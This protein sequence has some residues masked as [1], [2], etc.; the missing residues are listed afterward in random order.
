M[1]TTTATGQVASAER[2]VGLANSERAWAIVCALVRHGVR[3]VFVCPGSRS[4]PLVAAAAAHPELE[5]FLFYDERTAGFAA[6]GAGRVGAPAAVLTT[7]GTAV[8]NLHPALVEADL[9]DVPL[10]ALTADRPWELVGTGANQTIDQAGLFGRS[11]RS[12]ID[13]AAPPDGA[14]ADRV[15]RQLDAALASLGGPRPGPVHLNARFRKPLEPSPEAFREPPPP[16]APRHRASRLALGSEERVELQATLSRAERGLVVVGSL[17]P[18]QRAAALA[19][20]ERLGWPAVPD[21][22]SGLPRPLPVPTWLPAVA[23]LPEVAAALRPDV[24]LW[25]GGRTTEPRVATWV[26]EANA[27]VFQVLPTTAARDPDGTAHVLLHADLRELLPLVEGAPPSGLAALDARVQASRAD[28]PPVALSEP[29]VARAVT[30][31]I[32]PGELLLVG[33]SMPVRDV[34]RFADVLAAGASVL[35]NRGASGIDGNVGTALGACLAHGR[36]PTTALLG[37]LTFL[38]DAAALQAAVQARAPLRV[39]VVNNRGGGIFSFLPVAGH[40][41]VFEP[42]FG[43]PHDVDVVALARAWGAAA[44]RV[45]DVAD[46]RTRLGTPPE[47]PE[48][49]EVRTDRADNL[50]LHRALDEQAARRF[51]E[52]P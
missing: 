21:V 49:L 50:E 35:C 16:G 7:S 26:Q 39:V 24:V 25:L 23:R 14:S 47:R 18:G 8:A 31:S 12:F 29:A 46:L 42:F 43:T 37:D 9:D 51:R 5:L 33:N 1:T 17:P 6:V 36:A 2:A 40:A 48:V 28:L 19:V 3:R 32:R 52:A 15:T 11:A 44:S 27:R 20:V 13:L 41:E 38:H 30:S 10:V 4:T 34:D 22:T 45:D